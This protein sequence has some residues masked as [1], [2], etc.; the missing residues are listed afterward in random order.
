M[1]RNIDTKSK[2]ENELEKMH[3]TKRTTKFQ[4]TNAEVPPY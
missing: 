3:Q 2:L 4:N 1:G